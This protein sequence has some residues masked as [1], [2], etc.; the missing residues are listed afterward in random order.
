MACGVWEAKSKAMEFGGA[1]AC[2][3]E[4]VFVRI[5]GSL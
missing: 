3:D 1:D 5:G 4:V 2:A